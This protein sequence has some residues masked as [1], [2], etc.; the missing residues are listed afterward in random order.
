MY[1]NQYFKAVTF[2]VYLMV[3][4]LVARVRSHIMYIGPKFFLDQAVIQFLDIIR[5][6]CRL[7]PVFFNQKPLFDRYHADLY[8]SRKPD[9]SP[10]ST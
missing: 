9:T 5:N 1:E 4:H 7:T 2:G 6:G 3:Y 10:S 8:D